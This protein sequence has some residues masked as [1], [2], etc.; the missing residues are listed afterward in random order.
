MGN[1]IQY[2]G[3]AKK[4][5]N[6]QIGETD[7]GIAARSGKGRVL[8]LASDASNN[9]LSRAE[10]FVRGNNI[11]LVRIPFTKAEISDATGKNG[12]SM[13]VFTD[14]GLTTA[15]LRALAENDPAYK[16]L[17][18]EFDEKNKKMQ[19]RKQEWKIHE[20]NKKTGRAA[21]TV[22]PGKRRKKK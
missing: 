2:I 4:S 22:K 5:G 9:A 14:M 1:A 8:I 19:M 3:L 11:P 12:C 13:A 20:R 18:V 15:F 16:D 10:F 21:K 17:S 6:I 7:S